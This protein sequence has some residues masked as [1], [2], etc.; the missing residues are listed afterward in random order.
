MIRLGKDGG[1]EGDELIKFA[2]ALAI[3]PDCNQ[4]VVEVDHE[5]GQKLP[6]SETR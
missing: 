3:E 6:K 4:D 2:T 5:I 1:D